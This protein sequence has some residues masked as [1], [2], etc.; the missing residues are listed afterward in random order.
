MKRV[1]RPNGTASQA[2]RVLRLARDLAT[3]V[4]LNALARRYDV[5]PRTIRRDLDVLDRVL[6]LARTTDDGV[7]HFALRRPLLAK[8]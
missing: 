5:T 4:D 1:G 6:G 8:E 3:P 2:E 7:A